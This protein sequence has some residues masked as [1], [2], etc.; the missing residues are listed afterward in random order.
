MQQ[1]PQ[2]QPKISEKSQNSAFLDSRGQPV[3]RNLN[4]SDQNF[5]IAFQAGRINSHKNGAIPD[6]W[7][8]SGSFTTGRKKGYLLGGDQTGP[9]QSRK[10][11]RDSKRTPTNRANR[12]SI[13]ML[14]GAPE[15]SQTTAELKNAPKKPKNEEIGST[16]QTVKNGSRGVSGQAKTTG[17]VRGRENGHKTTSR[18]RPNSKKSILSH[19]LLKVDDPARGHQNTKNTSGKPKLGTNQ[20]KQLKLGQEQIPSYRNFN[21][22]NNPKTSPSGAEGAGFGL[23]NPSSSSRRRFQS[24]MVPQSSSSSMRKNPKFSLLNSSSRG[25]ATQKRPDRYSSIQP[26]TYKAKAASG[27]SRERLKAVIHK[28]GPQRQYESQNTVGRLNSTQM[29]HRAGTLGLDLG[30]NQPGSSLKSTMRIL[31]ENGKRGENRQKEQRSKIGGYVGGRG[32]DSRGGV[33]ADRL[34]RSNKFGNSGSGRG[35]LGG[36]QSGP[37]GREYSSRGRVRSRGLNSSQESGF[38]AK[39]GASGFGEVGSFNSK[40]SYFK[41]R[42]G[43]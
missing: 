14:Q 11:W 23:N 5:R 27:G 28:N 9:D 22:K 33:M 24:N 7:K 15:Y 35:A 10:V 19:R 8:Q 18:S 1:N 38:G 21:P 4:K 13:K 36:L 20:S 41:R 16:A 31:A 42:R 17:R 34:Y 25:L 30:L 2:K 40:F 3:S 12:G 26:S 29:D 37:G 6:S 43:I 39:N 32:G